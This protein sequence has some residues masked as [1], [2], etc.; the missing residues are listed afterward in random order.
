MHIPRGHANIF[1]QICILPVIMRVYA[2]NEKIMENNLTR[3]RPGESWYPG[4]PFDMSFVET[5]LLRGKDVHLI[6]FFD[7]I[8]SAS[9]KRFIRKGAIEYLMHYR[10]LGKRMAIH[11]DGLTEQGLR[12]RCTTAG[13]APY[14]DAYFGFAFLKTSPRYVGRIKDFKAMVERLGS[15]ITSAIVIGDGNSETY[16][17]LECDIDLLL[18]PSIGFRTQSEDI[19]DFKSLI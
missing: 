12:E 11:S 2:A 9:R 14:I 17:S 15:D 1:N 6:D 8:C 19:F 13:L 3:I 7:T 16:A 4:G 5:S 18:V 10:G